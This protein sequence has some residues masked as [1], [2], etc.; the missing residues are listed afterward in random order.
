MKL[1]KKNGKLIVDENHHPILCDDCPCGEDPD[2]ITFEWGGE[3]TYPGWV[4]I[5]NQWNGETS[6]SWYGKM[7]YRRDTLSSILQTLSNRNYGNATF[8]Q[9]ISGNIYSYEQFQ[10]YIFDDYFQHYRIEC[11]FFGQKI[12]D[13][14]YGEYHQGD[15]SLSGIQTYKAF[16]TTSSIIPSSM[17][18][19]NYIQT[20]YSGIIRFQILRLDEED[21]WRIYWPWSP[22]FDSYPGNGGYLGD[23]GVYNLNLKYVPS[24]NPYK[25]YFNL[26]NYS[27]TPLNEVWKLNYLNGDINNQWT[28]ERDEESWYWYD[29]FA[30]MDAFKTFEAAGINSRYDLG[31]N[32]SFEILPTSTDNGFPMHDRNDNLILP[33]GRCDFYI[34][35]KP[36][37][38]K[39]SFTYGNCWPGK[40]YEKETMFHSWMKVK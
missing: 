27:S 37:Q 31:H 35:I 34:K 30:Y 6:G 33:K 7:K 13:P 11:N 23:I 26:N 39:K 40:T 24:N 5:N 12:D 16:L 4:T 36:G 20:N 10:D 8:D 15:W 25:V 21:K 19:A 29:R 18:D 38:L 28:D 32:A 14:D 9:S 22:H 2:Y 1:W 17:I 3:Y